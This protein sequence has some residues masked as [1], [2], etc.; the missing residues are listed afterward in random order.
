MMRRWKPVLCSHPTQERRVRVHAALDLVGLVHLQARYV[1][2][3]S[4][5]QMQRAALARALVKRPAVVL[6]DE[7][8][9]ALD[10]KLRRQ[11]QDEI[12][13]LKNDI[14]DRKSVV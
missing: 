13:R 4:G 14:G 12:V 7:P 9:G 11:M 5:G 6:L 1:N 10:L 8:L 2:E 3:L